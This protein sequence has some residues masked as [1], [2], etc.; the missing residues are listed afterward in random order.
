[1][2]I[3]QTIEGNLHQHYAV[4]PANTETKPLVL[5]FPSWSGLSQLERHTA[6]NIAQWGYETVAIDLYGIHANPTTVEEKQEKMQ[7]LI[8]ECSTLHKHLKHILTAPEFSLGKR[9]VIAAGFC[10]GGRLAIESGLSDIGIAGV[11]S[12]HGILNVYPATSTHSRFLILNGYLD[13]LVNEESSKNFK[14]LLNTLNA[15]WQFVDF[16]ATMH[17][18]TNPEANDPA[19]GKAYNEKSTR[20]AMQYFQQ[21]LREF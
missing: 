10:L 5:L 16:G 21:F 4:R 13:P 3:T 8:G 2:N 9:T 11:A 1:M 14:A 6:D 18:F 7:A 20:R 19:D 17:A 12:F 15:D